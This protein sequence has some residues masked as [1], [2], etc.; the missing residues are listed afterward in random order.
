[1]NNALIAIGIRNDYLQDK[2]LEVARAIGPVE[3]DQGE[4]NCRTPD[5][6][7]YILRTVARKHRHSTKVTS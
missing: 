1:M 2:A 4:T 3:V 6:A 5:A 7:A